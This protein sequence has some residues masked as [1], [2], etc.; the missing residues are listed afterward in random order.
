MVAGP[1]GAIIGGVAGALVGDASAKGKKPIKRAA[2]AVQA[3]LV[4]SGKKK[5]A[6]KAAKK[7]AGKQK[8]SATKAKS[9]KK[10]AHRKTAPKKKG[11]KKK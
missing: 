6:V 5:V 3:R 8:P 1:V 9:A 10:G 11:A 4:G 2:Q 7:S